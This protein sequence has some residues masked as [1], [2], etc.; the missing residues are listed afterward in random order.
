M[1]IATSSALGTLLLGMM[2]WVSGADPAP[3]QELNSTPVTVVMR[4]YD[5]TQLLGAPTLS[6]D[7]RKGRALW[8]Q[9][10]AYCHDGVGQPT[11]KTMGSWLGAETV[12]LLGPDALRAIIGAGTERMPG[13]RYTL[14]PQQVTQLIEFLKTVTADQ[15][16]TAAQLARKSSGAA[17][18]LSG[19]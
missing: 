8:L 9:R 19:E 12:Q 5:K 15:K 14:Q 13:F 11:Y 10:C 16:P 17:A 6:S 3:A 18:Q 2:L 4:A 1:S 7:A